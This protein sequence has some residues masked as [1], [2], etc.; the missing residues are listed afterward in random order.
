MVPPEEIQHSKAGTDAL[1]RLISLG[2]FLPTTAKLSHLWSGDPPVPAL[3]GGQERGEDLGVTGRD[4]E[5]GAVEE[6]P[7][8]LH[9]DDEATRLF[10]SAAAHICSVCTHSI[11]TTIA[12]RISSRVP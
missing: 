7:R 11:A 1:R 10:I 8:P 12:L 9:V 6:H 4:V 5:L 3:L 2:R